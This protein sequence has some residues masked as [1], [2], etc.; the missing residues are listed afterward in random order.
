MPN[1]EGFDLVKATNLLSKRLM[2]CKKRN[3]LYN[4]I[5]LSNLEL[6]GYIEGLQF[7]LDCNIMTLLGKEN[8]K[9]ENES[10]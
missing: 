9:D 6:V 2:D 1:N 7:A 10:R 8:S 5:G 3:D 4:E